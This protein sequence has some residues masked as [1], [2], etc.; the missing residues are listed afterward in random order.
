MTV[1]NN[2]LYNSSYR[3]VSSWLIGF[4][5]SFFKYTSL[6]FTLLFALSVNAVVEG[7][8]YDFDNEIDKHRFEDLAEELR[9]PK[10]QNQNLADSNAPVARD[11]RDKLY[12]LVKDGRSDMEIMEYMVARYGD[13]VRYKPEMKSSTWVLWFGPAVMM[14]IA[15][16][17]VV[18][19]KQSRKPK[20]DKT[21]DHELSSEELAQLEVLKQQ[22]S[23]T[24]SPTKSLSK[25]QEQD[26]H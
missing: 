26:K 4:E 14:F 16:L 25:S 20:A 5:M 13:F 9:C 1:L 18:A 19:L 7:Y 23:Q 2:Q 3:I 21:S 15:V 17:I 10:C 6:L 24:E 8:K 22:N 11:L 12:E